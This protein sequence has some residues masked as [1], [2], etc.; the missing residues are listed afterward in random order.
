ML[1]ACP[2]PTTVD[3]DWASGTTVDSVLGNPIVSTTTETALGTYDLHATPDQLGTPPPGATDLLVV[4]DPDNLVSPAD[5]SKVAALTLT[6]IAV[7]S[8]NW[9][10]DQEST[11]ITDPVDAGGVDF[12][13]HDQ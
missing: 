3:L 8:L 2:K 4:V 1:R 12:D 13:V 9:H 5:P 10:P 7:T 6:N 11:W